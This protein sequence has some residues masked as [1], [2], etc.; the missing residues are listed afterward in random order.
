MKKIIQTTLLLIF[1]ICFTSCLD[2]IEEITM[3]KDG[4]GSLHLTID[5]SKSKKNL[6]GYLKAGEVNGVKIPSQTEIEK[7]MAKLEETLKKTKGISNVN[8]SRDFKEFIFEVKGDF[9][10]V[11]ALNKAINASTKTLNQTPFPV[12]KF[13]HY[14]FSNNKFSRLFEYT[15]ERFTEEE[16]NDFSFVVRYLLESANL[17]SIYRFEEPVKKMSNKNANMSPSKKAIKLEGNAAEFVKGEKTLEN[18]ISF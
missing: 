6:A 15:D 2:V 7:D 3:N 16:Y 9:V 18:H 11:T 8:V 1:T 12:P 14:S 13:K 4:S 10:D 17:V 5:L